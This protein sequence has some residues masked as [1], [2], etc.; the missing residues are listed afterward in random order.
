MTNHERSRTSNSPEKVKAE[1]EPR[2]TL[3]NRERALPEERSLE[4]RS[5]DPTAHLDPHRIPRMNN[6]AEMLGITNDWL[7]YNLRYTPDNIPRIWFIVASPYNR[8]YNKKQRFYQRNCFDYLRKY[9]DLRLPQ[10]YLMTK[11]VNAAKTHVNI[12]IIDYDSE[13]DWFLYDN[14]NTPNYRYSVQEVDDRQ[15]SERVLAYMIKESHERRFS[16][17]SD[18]VYNNFLI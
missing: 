17:Y 4:E 15:N 10:K 6:Y 11:E 8:N 1:P 5:D 13:T 16:K 9:F 14:I 2:V 3:A 18:F 12:L 7:F